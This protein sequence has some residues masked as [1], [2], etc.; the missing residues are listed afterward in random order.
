RRSASRSPAIN[1][2][3]TATTTIDAA[4]TVLANRHQGS[5]VAVIALDG[6]R[7]FG[8][9]AGLVSWRFTMAIKTGLA[10]A[11]AFAAITGCAGGA[12]NHPQLPHAIDKLQ[13]PALLA[14]VPADTPYVFASFESLPRWYWD[15]TIEA[16]GPALADQ[17]NR[18]PDVAQIAAA[19]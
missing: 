15:K 4:V 2:A 16:V 3:P 10:L 7:V 5:A 11:I 1:T 6:A 14:N 9:V 18:N 17:L 13:T 19:V 12:S 8:S